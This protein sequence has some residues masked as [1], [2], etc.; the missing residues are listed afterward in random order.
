M[1]LKVTKVRDTIKPDLAR[2]LRAAQNPQKV[3]RAMG[4]VFS[5]LAT[6]AFNE[7]G[8]RPTPWAPLK[9]ETLRAK[10]AKGHSEGVLKATGTLM[11][12]PRVTSVTNKTVKVGSDRKYAAYHQLGTKNGLPPRPFFPVDAN[13]K[14]TPRA[15]TLVNAAA[16]RALDAELGMR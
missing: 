11:R 3:L 10:A 5:S 4:T 2:K 12:S 13:G 1:I 6:R 8:L 16:K 14:L 9:P 7:A 15:T